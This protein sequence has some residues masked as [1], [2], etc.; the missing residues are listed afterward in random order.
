MS[1]MVPLAAAIG[2]GTNAYRATYLL[3]KAIAEAGWPKQAMQYLDRA[4]EMK[5][6]YKRAREFRDSLSAALGH[7]D[8]RSGW[9]RPDWLTKEP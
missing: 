3:G 6:D 2:L 8:P 4:L 1:A 5:P 7:G 9:Q